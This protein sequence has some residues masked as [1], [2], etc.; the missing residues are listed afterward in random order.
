MGM[1]LIKV[2]DSGDVNRP[3]TGDCPVFA[4]REAGQP[5]P[6]TCHSDVFAGRSAVPQRYFSERFMN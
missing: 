5:L 4:I 2:L 6:F 1:H 3:V